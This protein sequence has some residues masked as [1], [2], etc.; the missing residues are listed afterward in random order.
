M[1]KKSREEKKSGRSLAVSG[2]PVVEGEVE[3]MVEEEEENNGCRG[4]ETERILGWMD[5][6]QWS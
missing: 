6:F 3:E 1:E 2:R 4:S 5:G